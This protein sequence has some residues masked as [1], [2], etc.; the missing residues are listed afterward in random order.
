MAMN[1]I[2]PTRL[3]LPGLSAGLVILIGEYVLNAMV[4]AEPWAELRRTFGIEEA[5]SAQ[6]VGGGLLTI[7]YGVV[8]MW[9]FA[10][11]RASFRT[12]FG[13]AIAAAMTF[14]LIAYVMFLLS[15]WA[16]GFVTLPIALVSIAWGFF[17]APLA[18]VIGTAIYRKRWR[19]TA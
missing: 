13:A 12:D 17:E 11:M 5:G 3:L 8:L 16:N 6:L 4:L 18:A 2:R 7:L 1:D 14:W 19:S 15:V 9:M 10:S